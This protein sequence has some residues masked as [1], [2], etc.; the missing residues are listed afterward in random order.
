MFHALI[1]ETD[2][3][4]FHE[5]TT[6]PFDPRTTEQAPWAPPADDAV[7]GLAFLRAVGTRP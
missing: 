5:T 2:H 1:V 6:G 7:A 3:L 4:V